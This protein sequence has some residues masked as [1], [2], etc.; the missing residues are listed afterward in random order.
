MNKMTGGKQCTVLWH[1]DDLKISHVDSAV[2]EDVLDRLTIRYGMETPHTVTRGD[3]HEY[4]GMTIDYSTEGKVVIRVNDYVED[5]LGEIPNAMAGTAT[6][7]AAEH[8]FKV[9]ENAE[10]L[11][12]ADLDLFHSVTAKLL[13]LCKRA[14]PDRIF[15]H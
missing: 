3:I 2:I 5:L 11:N 14:R 6:T 9:D 13:F 4:L 8:L 12:G 10:A 7:P 1:D 15:V